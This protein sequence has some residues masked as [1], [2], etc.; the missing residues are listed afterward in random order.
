LRTDA[1][2]KLE[3]HFSFTVNEADYCH[4]DRSGTA[5]LRVDLLEIEPHLLL[6]QS[7]GQALDGFKG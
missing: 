5:P 6:S 7:K 4:K 3:R 2:E 1:N